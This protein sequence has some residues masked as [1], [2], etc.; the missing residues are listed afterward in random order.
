MNR[1]RGQAGRGS[2]NNVN[3]RRVVEWVNVAG[4]KG[5]EKMLVDEWWGHTS[6][7]M[8]GEGGKELEEEVVVM[9]DEWVVWGRGKDGRQLVGWTVDRRW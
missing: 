1:W 7:W 9:V 6:D 4:E 5:R 8:T 2:V 3:N